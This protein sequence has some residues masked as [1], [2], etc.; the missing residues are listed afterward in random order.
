MSEYGKPDGPEVSM[1][2]YVED[3]RVLCTDSQN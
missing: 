2:Y 1:L 3:K